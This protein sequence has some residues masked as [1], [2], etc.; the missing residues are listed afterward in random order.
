[1]LKRWKS[2]LRARRNRI[3]SNWNDFSKRFKPRYNVDVTMY[4]F[5]PGMPVKAERTRHAFNK[6]AFDEAK[7]FFDQRPEDAIT[8]L[9]EAK[10]VAISSNRRREL[11]SVAQF[12]DSVG[13]DIS[14][15]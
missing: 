8:L 7:L 5:I 3:Q 12:A 11:A 14:T 1:M 4:Q 15:I 10:Q 13:L 9:S 2:N 6:G